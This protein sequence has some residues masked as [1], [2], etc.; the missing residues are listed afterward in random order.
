MEEGWNPQFSKIYKDV[1]RVL[2]EI[3][4][5]KHIKFSARYSIDGWAKL[6]EERASYNAAGDPVFAKISQAFKDRYG[7]AE[8]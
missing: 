1:V 7:L 4:G 3:H 8:D 6:R 2:C 5:F